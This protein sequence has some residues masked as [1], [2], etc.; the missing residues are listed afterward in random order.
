MN[1]VLIVGLTGGIGSG[2]SAVSSKFEQL[3]IDVID[4]DVVSREVVKIDSYALN[5]IAQHFG[6][7]ILQQDGSLDRQTLREIVFAN[8]QEK[9]WLENL[10]HP[11]IRNQIITQL[12]QSK[13]PYAILSS[14]LL[15]ETNQYELVNRILV[16]D[17]TEELQIERACLRDANKVEQIKKIMATQMNRSTRCSRADDIIHNHGAIHE[18]DVQVHRLHSQ[19]LSLSEIFLKK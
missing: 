3:G 17:A 4:A 19:Y 7:E 10:L 12:H 15:L 16:V 6:L 5:E 8:L 1:R 13:S 14:P 18:L 11:I 9:A 2:K